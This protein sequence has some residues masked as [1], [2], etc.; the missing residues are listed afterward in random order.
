MMLLKLLWEFVHNPNLE[1]ILNSL[2]SFATV[3]MFL[4]ERSKQEMENFRD[5][6]RPF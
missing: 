5:H 3:Q 2:L 1:S 6:V 4:A